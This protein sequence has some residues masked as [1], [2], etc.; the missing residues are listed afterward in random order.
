[1]SESD[2]FARRSLRDWLFDVFRTSYHT[3]YSTHR[4]ELTTHDDGN[5]NKQPTTE[6]PRSVPDARTRLLESYHRSDPPCGMRNCSHGTFSPR[7]DDERY[8]PWDVTSKQPAGGGDDYG[9]SGGPSRSQPTSAHGSDNAPSM[10]SSAS[11]LP[12]KNRKTLYVR[13]AMR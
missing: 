10:E 8:R 12:L 11:A 7:P 4:E 13:V 9:F 1:M 2:P 6:T 5:S 3:G